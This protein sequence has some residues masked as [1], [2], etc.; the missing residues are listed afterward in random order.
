MDVLQW[1]RHYR[2]FPGQGQFDLEN[3]FEL[4]LRAGYT[5]PLSLEIFNDIFRE[6]PN[7]RTATDAMRSLLY[8]EGQVRGRLEACARSA[9]AR[10]RRRSARVLDAGR[11]VRPAGGTAASGIA[12]L[13]FAVDEA[14]G[15]RARRAAA[16]SWAS[17]APASIAPRTSRCTGR[18]AS[19]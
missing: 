1:A 14:S 12:F 5:G 18:A 16:S 10:P 17:G 9:T 6:T 4:T 13:E 19:T 11:V 7:R 2:N 15:A 3:F 8:L